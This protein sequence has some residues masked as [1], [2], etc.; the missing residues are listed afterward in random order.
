MVSSDFRKEARE[1]LYGKWGKGACI[2]LAYMFIIIVMDLIIGVFS[3]NM[4]ALLS[5]VITIIE[6]P[7]ALGLIISLVRLFNGEDVKAFDFLSSGFNNFG[8]SW[9]IT[10]QICLKLILPIIL[11]IVS[12]IIIAFATMGSATAI[13]Y[14]S[15]SSAS[16]FFLFIG[17]ILLLV[18]SIWIITK[19]YYYQ[20]AYIVVAEKP[21]TPAE[22]AVEQSQKLMNGKRAK[23]F[24]LQLS[25]IGWA[26]L[27]VFTLNIGY[28]W[29]VPYIQFAIVA[30]YKFVAGNND[31]IE[32]TVVNDNNINE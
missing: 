28:L 2:T 27:C 5:L 26:I 24:W 3:D 31:S 19:S 11:E 8:K 13:L 4:Q 20:L 9:A 6:V 17:I 21:E 16:T 12:Y 1:K 22:E 30:F 7:L 32:T 23:L 18:A 10:F 15:T 25:F 14:N 29:L